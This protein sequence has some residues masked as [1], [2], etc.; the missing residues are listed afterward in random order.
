MTSTKLYKLVIPEMNKEDSSANACDLCELSGQLKG[1]DV[2][3]DPIEKLLR[4]AE[5]VFLPW[6]SKE[7]PVKCQNLTCQELW[8]KL[9]KFVE[10]DWS[11][12]NSSITNL[13]SKPD[14]A[15]DKVKDAIR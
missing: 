7:E 11:F 12:E 13:S 2:R 1:K 5:V 3:E 14:K 10:V 15:E 8:D 6:G 9:Q 4:I